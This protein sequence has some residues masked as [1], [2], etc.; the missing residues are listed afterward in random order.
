MQT[1]D[2]MPR[3]PSGAR[4]RD[5]VARLL[6]MCALG[7]AVCAARPALAKAQHAATDGDGRAPRAARLSDADAPAAHAALGDVAIPTP[8]D[9]PS[10]RA[11]RA[12]VADEALAE[13]RRRILA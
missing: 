12:Q 6:R 8:A 13:L 3:D 11:F 4:T 5:G 1:L 7:V 10:I 9:D 2:I